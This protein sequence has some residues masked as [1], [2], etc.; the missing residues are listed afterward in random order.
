MPFEFSK[1]PVEERKFVCLLAKDL[2]EVDWSTQVR[3]GPKQG[4]RESVV[5]FLERIQETFSQVYGPAL[6]WSSHHR[7]NLIESVVKGVYD[8][9]SDPHS[10]LLRQLPRCGGAVCSKG[11]HC[12]TLLLR[13]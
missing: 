4:G 10:V 11:A 5:C 7:T 1:V 12:P 6:G 13:S 9:K 2:T 3:T 8:R